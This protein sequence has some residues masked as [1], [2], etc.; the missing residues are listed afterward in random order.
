VPK[1]VPCQAHLGSVMP[2]ELPAS[3]HRAAI[4]IKELNQRERNRFP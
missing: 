3:H 4:L 2:T 1:L